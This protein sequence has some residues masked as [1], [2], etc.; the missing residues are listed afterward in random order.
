MLQICSYYGPH[1][2]F[3]RYAFLSDYLTDLTLSLHRT[4]LILFKIGPSGV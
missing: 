1:S 2:S 4:K 3:S